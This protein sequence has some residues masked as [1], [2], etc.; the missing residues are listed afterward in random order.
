MSDLQ[1]KKRTAYQQEM[2]AVRLSD[3]KAEETLRLMLEKNRALHPAKEE[4]P[5]P[6]LRL[7]R[8]VPAF[9]A[10]AACLVLA[11]V[12]LTRGGP[13]VTFGAI[14]TDTLPHG[15]YRGADPAAASFEDV[16]GVPA[17]TLFPGWSVSDEAVRPDRGEAKLNLTKDGRRL[18]ASVSLEEPPL[19]E[20]LAGAGVE[21][22]EGVL[23]NRDPSDGSLQAVC[24]L[25][26]CFVVLS[27]GGLSEDDFVTA[28]RSVT[29]P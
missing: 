4:T 14:R 16:F 27:A 28:V 12:L 5:R 10:A 9:A 26:D 25:K 20:A 18:S 23:Y 17:E 1:E 19:R 11:V 24:R 22:A 3:A 6:S 8:L 2:D 15:G 13:A 29:A 7:R 21:A